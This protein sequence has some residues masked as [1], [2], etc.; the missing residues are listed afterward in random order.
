MSK[1]ERKI[2]QSERK[3]SEPKTRL[4]YLG[5]VGTYTKMAADIYVGDHH[6]K[7][8]LVEYETIDEA[9]I[10]VSKGSIDEAV[11]PI[12]NSS[13]G[14][15]K[16][17][18]TRFEELDAIGITGEVVLPIN[19][20]LYMRKDAKP[21]AVV[22]KDQAIAQC[23][24][25]IKGLLP[26]ARLIEENSTAKAVQMAAEDPK[27][28]AIGSPIAARDLGL[29]NVLQRIDNFSDD[30]RNATTF[31]VIKKNPELSDQTENDKTTFIIE[32]EDQPGGLYDFL[33]LLNQKGI[34][35]NKIKSLR[36]TDGHIS[37][38]VSVD[39]HQA[40]QNVGVAFSELSGKTSTI[41]MLGSYQKA[42]YTPS[43]ESREPN[44]E[45]AIK[46]I[47][48]EVQNGEL[49]DDNQA[50]V[51]F[52]LQNKPGALLNML[53]PFQEEGINL[54]KID[55]QA[56][57]IFEEYIFYLAYDRRSVQNEEKL[58]NKLVQ[59]CHELVILK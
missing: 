54:T 36:K 56:S 47:K 44:M 22:S 11:V 31:V 3:E 59:N 7:F 24:M 46:R 33:Y 23:E 4:G 14:P 12:E 27:I 13:A 8:A 35:L 53:K 55:S 45:N 6:E 29:E 20:T 37:F 5:P 39:G 16:N 9:M 21:E 42:N 43:V 38:L 18:H 25:N 52:T 15:V 49:A 17:T 10:A 48:A 32:L 58:R 50:V 1:Q 40:D 26:E 19:H 34:N 41:K 51:V 2:G 57:G 28:A 30:P